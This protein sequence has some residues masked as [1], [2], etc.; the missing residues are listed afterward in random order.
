VLA[1]DVVGPS[2][3]EIR[4]WL[5]AVEKAAN[6]DFGDRK[7]RVRLVWRNGVIDTEQSYIYVGSLAPRIV[8]D[9]YG[10]MANTRVDVEKGT[11]RSGVAA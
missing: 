1:Q 8:L 2:V 4:A 11:F 9:G 5:A 10:M 7:R 3:E 6:K